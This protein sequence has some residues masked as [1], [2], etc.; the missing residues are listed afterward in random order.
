MMRLLRHHCRLMHSCRSPG[1]L[2]FALRGACGIIIV[3]IMLLL[4]KQ[5]EIIQGHTC[6]S[7]AD[8]LSQHYC[9][10]IALSGA[11]ES[12]TLTHQNP[13]RAVIAIICALRRLRLHCSSSH[14]IIVIHCGSRVDISFLRLFLRRGFLR[15][16]LDEH[17][18]YIITSW[19]W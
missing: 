13:R 16:M 10:S 11:C 17:R 6:S 3:F 4:A 19:H 8:L 1:R 18:L 5:R 14:N 12:F 7:Q 2:S 9:H 15:I